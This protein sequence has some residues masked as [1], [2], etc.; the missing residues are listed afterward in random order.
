MVL[1]IR[2]LAASVEFVSAA[3]PAATAAAIAALLLLCQSKCRELHAAGLHDSVLL[4]PL[5]V[6][7]ASTTWAGVCWP[8]CH[9]AR[10]N[11]RQLTASNVIVGGETAS[12]MVCLLCL[13]QC[14]CTLICIQCIGLVQALYPCTAL[15]MC[16]SVL[17]H[18]PLS[19]LCRYKIS[20]QPGS[21]PV[22]TCTRVNAALHSLVTGLKFP[23]PV[24]AAPHQTVG[25]GS[26]S[27]YTKRTAT[28]KRFSI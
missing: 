6:R 23:I 12:V 27:Q 25:R 28:D 22:N 7:C 3:I 8:H 5:V 10:W 24:A 21:G 20:I 16:M 18:L 19:S 9:N 26:L 17:R 14:D 4:C 2:R 1:H 11:W 15:K 13:T